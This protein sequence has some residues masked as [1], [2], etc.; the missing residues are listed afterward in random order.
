MIYCWNSAKSYVKLLVTQNT[1]QN[2]INIEVNIMFDK[3][4]HNMNMNS[5]EVRDDSA[6][7][8]TTQL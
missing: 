2:G 4:K 6:H 7:G 5:D 1:V 3:F 8:T